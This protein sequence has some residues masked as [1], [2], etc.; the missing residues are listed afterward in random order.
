MILP[1]AYSSS[2]PFAL[3]ILCGVAVVALLIFGEG[4]L[5][6]AAASEEK[7][8]AMDW[9]QLD[10]KAGALLAAS[11]NQQELVAGLKQ[12]VGA[13]DL[14]SELLLLNVLVRLGHFDDA[15]AMI[16][17]FAARVPTTSNARN[18]DPER[19]LL[20]DAAQYLIVRKAFTPA[21][22]F[23]EKFPQASPGYGFLL[24]QQL[25]KSEGDKNADAWAA[26][27]QKSC[28]D[29]F[30]LQQRLRW[31]SDKHSAKALF[32][33]LYLHVTKVPD[34]F[35]EAQRFIHL[36]N[37][38]SNDRPDLNGLAELLKPK[39]AYQ[40]FLLGLE[41][42]MNWPK[43]AVAMYERS[44]TLPFT[45]QDQT[46]FSKYVL[47]HW[48]IA[49]SRSGIEWKSYWRQSTKQNLVHAY[50]NAHEID[51]ARTLMVELSNSK[52]NGLPSLDLSTLAGQIQ[53][54]SSEHP[55][56]NKIRQAEA[57]NTESCDYWLTRATYYLGRKD[58]PQ[59]VSAYEKAL[60]LSP[61]ETETDYYKRGAV[62]NSYCRALREFAAPHEE[63]VRILERE[64]A[65]AV[66][67]THYMQCVLSE[68][69]WVDDRQRGSGKATTELI[70][71]DKKLWQHLREEKV[72]FIEM[73]RVLLSLQ[74]STPESSKAQFWSRTIELTLNADASKAYWL[75]D[76]MK[77]SGRCDLGLKMFERAHEQ[78]IRAVAAA[79]K[80]GARA[81]LIKKSGDEN[82][83]AL[84]RNALFSCHI[85]M[86]DWKAAEII[87]REE[88]ATASSDSRQSM[89][90]QLALA[91]AR[92]RNKEQAMR[93]WKEKS[94]IDRNELGWLFDVAKAGLKAELTEYYKKMGQDDP[95]SQAPAAALLVLN[96][97]AE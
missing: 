46:L 69:L 30:W 32:D 72:W 25:A 10:N 35:D 89:L 8:K 62:L 95:A 26:S 63:T 59:A 1:S 39:L 77:R 45:A 58:K 44:L 13:A 97:V 38:V 6:T 18:D 87:W 88:A 23:V 40:A 36:V 28:P 4:N 93:F 21:K 66:P 75:A 91:A 49:N 27:M 3:R 85:E 78:A 37:S 50:K 64:Y 79:E 16:N 41:L 94:S 92:A 33:E 80:L 53:A 17:K 83:V 96:K 57:V 31:R 34:N 86:N 2:K 7:A 11:K 74:A 47:S 43:S 67:G 61:L 22:L 15:A 52:P 68:M 54:Q 5:A 56:E 14:V 82:M 65:L 29:D 24:I 81:D 19:R 9:Y 55:V 48:A 12:K 60:S 76:V 73:S 51:K 71:D 84:T 70:R 42:Q 20:S 90:A